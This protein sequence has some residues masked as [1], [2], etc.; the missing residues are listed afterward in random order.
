VENERG[1][2]TALTQAM[3]LNPVQLLRQRNH[4][5]ALFM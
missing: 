2:L 5:A 1:V 4:V 3:R